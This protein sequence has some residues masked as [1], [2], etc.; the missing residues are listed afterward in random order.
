M[1]HNNTTHSMKKA[2]AKTR[3]LTVRVRYAGSPDVTSCKMIA[4]QHKHVL[5]FMPKAIFQ[6]ATERGKLLVAHISTVSLSTHG[7]CPVDALGETEN[8]Q[9]V[10]FVRFNHRVR[11]TET[12][13]YDICVD[14][15]LQ[16]H[17]V[18]RA[19]VSTLVSECI[20]VPRSSIILRC[21][22]GVPAND[23]YRHIG[24]EQVGIESGKRRSLVVW[25]LP[26]ETF[27]CSS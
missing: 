22:E 19:L 26:V 5:G 12:A 10:G 13:L 17:G 9:I 7:E 1:V 16:H 2:I 6:E 15:E 20:K 24:F 3:E 21:P 4:D 23:F 25:H 11:G 18:G 8:V 14:T 27:L